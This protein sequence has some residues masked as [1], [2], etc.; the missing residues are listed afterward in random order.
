[1]EGKESTLNR[2]REQIAI[3]TAS[4]QQRVEKLI[5]SILDEDW[6]CF[7]AVFGSQNG[8]ANKAAFKATKANGAKHGDLTRAVTQAVREL[9]GVFDIRSVMDQLAADGF[10]V[11]AKRPTAAI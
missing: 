8:P 9:R 10:R 1:M 4:R 2:L 5:E 6:S 11:T 3:E 7:V